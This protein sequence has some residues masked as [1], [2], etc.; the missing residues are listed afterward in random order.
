MS[1]N[2]Y[3]PEERHAILKFIRA[4]I[5]AKLNDST[6]PQ[7]PEFGDKLDQQGSCFVTL[8]TAE[9]MLRGCIGNIAAYEPLG[10]NIA[11]NAV[12]AALNDPRFPTLTAAELKN[13]VIEISI[14]TPM[15]A[16]ASIDDFEIGKH[17]I[18]LI[19]NGRSSVFLP[20]VAPEQGWDKATTLTHLSL[21]AGLAQNA[22]QSEAAT[23]QVFEAIVFSENEI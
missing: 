14:L 13:V 1:E 18:V 2:T 16:I 20:Q 11:H 6:P 19:C 4:I 3:S 9:G 5:S 23:F 8:H 7:L 22:W 15:W 12:N 17:G 10:D 21:K